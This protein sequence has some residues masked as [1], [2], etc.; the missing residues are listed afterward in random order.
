M[1][2]QDRKKWTGYF[3]GE[4][5]DFLRA[6]VDFTE[7]SAD[8]INR[9]PDADAIWAIRDKIV[10]DLDSKSSCAP[11]IFYEALDW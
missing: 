5:A 11:E 1:T 7:L 8:A 4:A 9:L 10:A 3:R 2:P 6:Y